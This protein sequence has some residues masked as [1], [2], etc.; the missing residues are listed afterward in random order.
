MR[1]VERLEI[2]LSPPCTPSCAAHT[3]IIDKKKDFMMLSYILIL[4]HFSVFLLRSLSLS[5]FHFHPLFPSYQRILATQVQRVDQ[6]TRH[7]A[8]YNSIN[9]WRIKWIKK[10][11]SEKND[12]KCKNK[13]KKLNSFKTYLTRNIKYV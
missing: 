1:K 7:A 4:K 3:I 11:N 10:P 8:V 13:P 2:S 12:C 9:S 5:L 6:N